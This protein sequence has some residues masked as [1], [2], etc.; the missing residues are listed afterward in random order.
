VAAAR[1]VRWAADA[2]A[3]T[4]VAMAFVGRD[5]FGADSLVRAQ[6]L[7]LLLAAAVQAGAMLPRRNSLRCFAAAA[8]LVASASAALRGT[9]FTAWDGFLPRHL[10][11]GVMLLL[12][13][14]FADRFARVLEYLAAVVLLACGVTAGFGSSLVIGTVPAAVGEVYPGFAIATALVFGWLLK[15]RL[16]YG[17]AAITAVCWGLGRGGRV[18]G[19][20]RRTL[21]GLPYLI[22][23]LAAFAVALLIS[24]VKARKARCNLGRAGIGDY[25]FD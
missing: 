19:R 5:T 12:P 16:Y 11:L 4:L 1:R 6:A 2:G 25:P 22:A 24:L 15:N 20:F 9:W 14:L 10:V 8:L 21:P 18:Y 7:P 17:L 3:A 13:V 23:A